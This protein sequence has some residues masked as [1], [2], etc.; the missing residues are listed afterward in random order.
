MYVPMNYP[1]KSLICSIFK[2][3]N[4]NFTHLF[5]L[6]LPFSDGALYRYHEHIKMIGRSLGESLF[7]FFNLLSLN[8]IS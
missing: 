2:L 5:L 6:N 3:K 8:R 7:G 1:L 4:R